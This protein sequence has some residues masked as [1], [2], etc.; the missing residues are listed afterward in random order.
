ME[1]FEGREPGRPLEVRR[2]GSQIKIQELLS[3]YLRIRVELTPKG[4]VGNG[5][6][7]E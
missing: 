5:E 4:P 3:D 6:Q 2:V 1:V 7:W